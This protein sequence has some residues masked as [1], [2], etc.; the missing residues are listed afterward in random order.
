MGVV[1]SMHDGGLRHPDLN[2]GNL[3]VRPEQDGW[4]AFVLDLDRATLY[5]ERLCFALRVSSLR[6]LERSYVKNF[7]ADGPLGSDGSG[8][9]Y[10]LYA[11]DDAE[12]TSRLGRARRRGR[13]GLAWH[14]MFWRTR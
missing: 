9:F 1:R 2:L 4:Q 5:P 14:R 6:R 7:G 8:A 10:R 13:P 3:A 12:L 11:A